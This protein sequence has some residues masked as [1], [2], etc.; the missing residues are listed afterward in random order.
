MK[1]LALAAALLIA[2]PIT[3]ALA[4][5]TAISIWNTANPGGLETAIGT[6]IATL[7]PASL[8]GVT[9]ETS[10]GTRVTSPFNEVNGAQIL[11]VNTTGSSQT[12]EL[13]VGADNFIGVDNRYHQSATINLQSGTADLMGS[14]FV[15]PLNALGGTTASNPPGV[16]NFSFDS[17]S[18]TGPQAISENHFANF[19]SSGPLYSMGETLTLTLGAG[20]IVGVQGISMTSAPIPEAPTWAMMLGGFGLLAG[21]AY[22]RRRKAPRLAF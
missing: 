17:G 9:I 14:Y 7:G 16:N 2:A 11:L 3:P 5:N 22:A 19:P 12:V 21:V 20:A 4:Q 6:S 1:R 8:G 10:I 18:L 15:D 13:S